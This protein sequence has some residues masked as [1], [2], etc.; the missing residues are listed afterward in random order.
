M[1]DTTKTR[2][3]TGTKSAETPQTGSFKLPDPA[4]VG[5][6]MADIA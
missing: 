5:R 4:L 3:T 1:S 2:T 6:S